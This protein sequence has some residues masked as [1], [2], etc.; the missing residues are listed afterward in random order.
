MERSVPAGDA[1]AGGLGDSQPSEPAA[2]T[3]TAIFVQ[4]HHVMR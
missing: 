1:F 2:M 4:L 3:L